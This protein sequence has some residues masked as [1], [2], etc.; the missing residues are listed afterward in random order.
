MRSMTKSPLRLARTAL[1]VGRAGLPRYSSR[2]SRHD[3]TC[4]QLFAVL[5]LRRLFKSDYRG[6]VAIL[7]EWPQL[8]RTLRLGKVPN[9]A[10]LCYAEHRL[11]R[12]GRFEQL[13][14]ALFARA[15]AKGLI[16][17]QPEASIDATGLESRHVSTYYRRR[18]GPG[19]PFRWHR[20]PKLTV[21]VHSASHLIAGVVI[22]RGPSQDS[23]QFAPAMRQ[24]A[25]LLHPR[26]LLADAAYD[27]E[28]NH[29]LC[30]RE[31]GIPSTAIPINRRSAGRRWPR[32]PYRRLMKQRF[33]K[34][35][36]RQRWQ[37][38]S[39]ISRFKRRLGSAL[40][41]RDPQTQTDDTDCDYFAGVTMAICD[42]PLSNKAISPPANLSQC[43]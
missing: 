3:F 11:M 18:R 39:A 2:F 29:A 13:M 34:H 23:P 30:R 36:Y 15:R 17:N 28:H 31:L 8:R 43:V 5:A 38:E 7:A 24:A 9:H 4:A 37:S 35:K 26:R 25:A 27:A 22:G 32:T 40:T 21:V 19:P 41:A 33:P 42:R 16:E 14:Q 20:W 6:I 10:T 12:F 1:A